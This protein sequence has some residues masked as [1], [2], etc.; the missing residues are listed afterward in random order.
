M[1]SKMVL[2]SDIMTPRNEVLKGNFQGVIQTHKVNTK[3]S[4]LES[5]PQEF[6]DITYP[7]SVLKE[8]L[9]KTY[10]KKSEISN[11]GGFLLSGPYGSGKSHSLITLYHIFNNP[12][13][14]NKWAKKWDIEFE[15]PDNSKSII[16]STRNFDED[17]LWTPI[18][19]Q[20]G[21]KDLL[22]KVRKYPTINQIEELLDN[23]PVAIFIDE[24]ENWYGS[25]DSEKESDKIERN[26][27]F[28]EH[29]L[30]VANDPHENLFVFITFLE[31]KEGLKTIFNRTKP[32]RK[33][34]SS[35]A[36]RERVVLHRL[37][38]NT[39]SINDDKVEDIIEKYIEKYQEPIKIDDKL[40]YKR[41]MIKTYP[42][43]PI[44]LE[45]LT[46]VYEAAS[47][48]QNIRGMLNILADTIRETFDKKD[49][50]LLSDIDE[51]ALRGMNLRL[52]EQ[53]DSDLKKVKEINFGKEILKTILIFTIDEKKRGATESD[54]LLSTFSP[55][56]G[57]TINQIV[58][59]LE[60]VY[61]K[62]HYLYREN[63]IYLFKMDL[64]VFALLEREKNR[65]KDEEAY[66]R[67]AELVKKDVFKN[68]ALISNFE[69]IPDN[70]KIKIVVSLDSWGTD[71]ILKNKLNEFYN[72][73]KWQNTFI[74]ILPET[75]TV[76]TFEVNEKTKKMI[77]AEKLVDQVD[78]K[79]RNKLQK[80]IKDEK[81]TINEK[82]MNL[83]GRMVKWTSRDGELVQRLI[84]INPDL[85]TIRDKAG[86]DPSLCA[87]FIVREIKEKPDG[88]RIED[89]INNFR[90]F[91]RFPLILDEEIINRSIR[92]LKRDKRIIIQGQKGR[93]Y[94][95]DDPK[96]L[97]LEFA[98]FDPKYGPVNENEEGTEVIVEKNEVKTQE[99][100]IEN[101]ESLGNGS[102]GENEVKV[103][104]IRKKQI[105]NLKGNS[106]RVILSQ[107]EAR[108]S[109]KDQFSEITIKYDFKDNISK[110]DMMKFI[111]GLPSMQD[112]SKIEADVI[113]WREQ[114]AN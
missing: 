83:Y 65:I 51:N 55:T 42:F 88:V 77:A 90:Q 1:V 91:R 78:D 31:E 108:T 56:E 106:T 32:V 53:Y 86:N 33:D 27:T 25:F 105:L 8:I 11:Q 60:N 29:L 49:L 39:K 4:R 73:K 41:K 43:H 9:E 99:S 47:E 22:E 28:L 15:A 62:P 16:I 2:I 101:G 97:E 30:E 82:I 80:V 96:T 23:K 92:S 35:T 14:G 70:N 20:L 13:I 95:E 18:F 109:E 113:S 24:I 5:N 34:I 12:Q 107:L 3:E 59:D 93:W 102:N 50:I 67:V 21:R 44:L 46:E 75:E 98:I 69:E 66:K 72:G 63:G 94:I 37:F 58:M 89:I 112:D 38:E 64:N 79:E 54:I 104:D 45:T 71:E 52:V 110:K 7:S 40:K 36:D 76:L 84:N 103:E 85:S 68:N 10:E 61:G 6:L 87:D 111:K 19:E 100:S 57:S 81:K 17:Y 74:I 114:D 48:N 26:E